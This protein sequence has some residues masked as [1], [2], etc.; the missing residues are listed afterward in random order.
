M[1]TSPYCISIHP[2]MELCNLTLIDEN[3]LNGFVSLDPLCS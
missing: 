3:K 1:V 2:V